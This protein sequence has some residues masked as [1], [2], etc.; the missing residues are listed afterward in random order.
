MS[1]SV[2]AVAAAL[3]AVAG[4]VQAAEQSLPGAKLLVQDPSAN[5]ALRK[6]LLQ[7]K[8]PGALPLGDPTVAGAVLRIV[9]QGGTPADQTFDLPSAGWKRLGT[10]GFKYGSGATGGAV[11]TVL[12][13]R[14]ANG[15]VTLKV[16]V[17]GKGGPLAVVP[18]APG[19]EAVAVLGIGATDALCVSFGGIAGGV[20]R[21]DDARKWLVQ[22][23]NAAACPLLP[24]TTTTSVL[25]TTSTSATTSTTTATT[26]STTSSSTS[27]TAT[28]S[29]TS[30]TT[31]T[32]LVVELNLLYVHGLKSCPSS[33]MN[34]HNS[35]DELQ[36][37][38]DAALPARIAA[39]EAAHPGVHVVTNSAHA[40][41]YTATPSGIHPS[42]S[43]D[44]LD[45]DD[46]EVGDPGCS[47]TQQGQPCTTAYEWR[48][49]LAQEVNRLFP[50]PAKNVVLIGHS[51]GARVAMEVAS[52]TGPGGPN[53]QSWGVQDRIAGVVTVQG[54]IDQIGTSK[55]DV[56]GAASFETTC[57]NGDAI[58]GFGDSCAPGNGFCEWVGRVSA[59]PGAD[60]VATS[61][62]ALMLTSWGSCS[63]A[64]WTGRSDGTLPYDA[65][66][67]PFAVGLDMTP[68]PGET[69]R[70]VHGQRLGAFC[71]SDLTD[72]SKANHV[73]ARTAVRDRLLDWLFVAAPRVAAAGTNSTPSLD[74]QEQTPSFAMGGTC[75]A[76]EVDEGVEVV[77]V[78][79][80]PGFFDGDDHAIASG[81]FTV[82]N[83]A[84]CNGSY[85]WRQ[86]HDQDDPHAANFWWKTRSLRAVAPELV[87]A[88]PT[89]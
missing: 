68:A 71:H 18:P 57:K 67:S 16:L 31:T 76:G 86:A 51:A 61:R 34:A 15:I 73:A 7:A 23:A 52:N 25:P 19:D 66:A 72:P 11:R 48:Y 37:A 89:S 26:S 63:P 17:Q 78:C 55:Y 39:W 10:T 3:L 5:P 81:E 69:W 9:T 14:G 38:V 50:A 13:K 70:E 80:H 35:L 77:G 88:L 83:G 44:P 20:E 1:T 47:T 41:V 54:V 53:T 33:R 75:P 12:L 36:A 62:R 32:T 4:L 64:L 8:G 27:S 42:D 45:M 82:T 29:T 24:T 6:V 74:Y 56:V 84:T 30:S 87:G 46:W 60:W 79:R 58:A 43:P 59:T 22:R 49:R 21:T 65:Q 40:N 85:R 2:R 28:T